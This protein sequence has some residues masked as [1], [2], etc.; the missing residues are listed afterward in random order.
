MKPAIYRW[1][2]ELLK[3]MVEYELVGLFVLRANG[4]IETDNSFVQDE[5]F[6]YLWSR[7]L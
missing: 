4:S 7:I 1:N 6:S 5:L 2:E 3:Y